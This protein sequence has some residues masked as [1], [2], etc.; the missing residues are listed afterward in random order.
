MGIFVN[1]NNNVHCMSCCGEKVAVG[2]NKKR[3]GRVGNARH[4]SARCIIVN[5]GV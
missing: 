1:V 5:E 2:E 4:A 3:D